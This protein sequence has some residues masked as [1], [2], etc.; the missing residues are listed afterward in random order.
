MLVL[1]R[2]FIVYYLISLSLYAEEIYKYFGQA[3][4][5]KNKDFLYTDFH[6]EF[7]Q[8]GK[9]VSSVIEY[10]DKFGKIFAIKKIN[11]QKNSHIPDFT[12]EDFRDGYLEG[13][14][15]DGSKLT[16]KYRSNFQ[17][18]IE[19]KSFDLPEN[20]VVDGGFDYFIKDNWNSLIDGKKIIFHMF[21]SP[22]LSYYRLKVVLLKKAEFRGK[23]AH[24]FK[25]DLDSFLG[26][27]LPSVYVIYDSK[28]KRIVHYEG[29]S[30]II[31]ES[32]RNYLVRIVYNYSDKPK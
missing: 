23:Q 12:L 32:G 6:T 4:H 31:D 14:V 9:H 2:I 11:F 1:L 20:S 21:S 17:S 19:E 24:Y 7:I 15:L 18:R 13:A 3:Y 27:F 28:T 26:I 30:N 29:I 16:L 5:L 8:M 22:R 25:V 10:K